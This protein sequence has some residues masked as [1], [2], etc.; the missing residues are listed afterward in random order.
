M[1]ARTKIYIAAII[2]IVCVRSV[3]APVCVHAAALDPTEISALFHEANDLFQQANQ[4]A[5]TAPED[6]QSLYQQA[7]MRFERIVNEGG[8]ENGKLYYN[9]GNIYF[10]MHDIGRA[11][12]NYRRARQYIPNDANLHQN[13]AFARSMRADQI[14][15]QQHTQI[16]QVLFFWHYDLSINTRWLLFCFFFAIVWIS[17]SLKLFIRKSLTTWLIT[18]FT[19]LSALIAGSLIIEHVHLRQSVPG[20]VISPEIIARKG[21]SASYETSFKAPLHAGTEF[22]VIEKRGG[23]FQIELSDSRTCWVPASDI[24]LVRSGDVRY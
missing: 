16:L 4:R 17:A 14:E 22:T 15:E 18:I 12:L 2:I 6:A 21:N 20:V 24:E 10:R 11:I 23:W 8:L 7:V 9:I 3:S 13:L 1:I 19:I 5:E